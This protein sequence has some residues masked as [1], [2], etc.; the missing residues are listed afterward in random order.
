M[1]LRVL[2][3]EILIVRILQLGICLSAECIRQSLQPIAAAL[4]TEK[5]KGDVCTKVADDL[6]NTSAIPRNPSRPEGGVLLA[7]VVDTLSVEQLRDRLREAQVRH[8]TT[9]PPTLKVTPGSDLERKV[10]YWTAECARICEQKP[11]NGHSISNVMYYITYITYDTLKKALKLNGV[12]DPSKAAR[13]ELTRHLQ[14]RSIKTMRHRVY[15]GE[16]VFKF[17]QL[18]GCGVLVLDQAGGTKLE[19]W[20][21]GEKWTD[22]ERWSADHE[23]GKKWVERLKQK[24]DITI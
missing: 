21:G 10:P 17:T 18:L 13:A 3:V 12:E 23:E 4:D 1:D 14:G 24:L 22:F 6:T 2:M 7:R 16:L 19:E 20:F 11:D 8:G 15:R 9:I 5:V